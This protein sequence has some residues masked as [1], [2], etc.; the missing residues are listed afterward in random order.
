MSNGPDH[1]QGIF[2]PFV[3]QNIMLRLQ[4]T[5]IAPSGR[6]GKTVPTVPSFVS[7]H[8]QLPMQRFLL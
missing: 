3:G 8:F 1:T 4:F 6:A 2:A 5:G 7:V